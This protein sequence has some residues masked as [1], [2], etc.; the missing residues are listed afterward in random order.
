MRGHAYVALLNKQQDR[1]ESGFYGEY[2]EGE[3]ACA[4]PVEAFRTKHTA[5]KIEEGDFDTRVW[6]DGTATFLAF[7]PSDGRACG[8][9]HFDSKLL[10]MSWLREQDIAKAKR[11]VERAE[12]AITTAVQRLAEAE[13]DYAEMKELS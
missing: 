13:A 3:N 1:W 10:L 4:A 7:H 12:E 6:D 2:G 9:Q 8:V 11:D 5:E